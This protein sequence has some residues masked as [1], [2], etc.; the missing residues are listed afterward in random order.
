MMYKINTTRGG[1]SVEFSPIKETE[2]VITTL[3]SIFGWHLTGFYTN[4]EIDQ[5]TLHV[6][7]VHDN[8][9]YEHLQHAMESV[10]AHS[11]V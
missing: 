5:V 9:H 3:S 1:Y 2:H 7:S 6:K 4:L 8:S 11:N 10:C